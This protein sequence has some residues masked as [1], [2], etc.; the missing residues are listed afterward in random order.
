[1]VFE[2]WRCELKQAHIWRKCFASQPHEGEPITHSDTLT[3]INSSGA[4]LIDK[5]HDAHHYKGVRES[6]SHTHCVWREGTIT[7]IS[8]SSPLLSRCLH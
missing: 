4:H 8:E 6:L 2:K 5:G 1:M 7:S 3:I